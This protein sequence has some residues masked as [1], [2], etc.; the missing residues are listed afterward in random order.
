M[1]GFVMSNYESWVFDT[2]DNGLSAVLFICGAVSHLLRDRKL[3]FVTVCAIIN[4][5]LWPINF[6][7]ALRNYLRA[8]EEELEQDCIP[9]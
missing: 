3:S 7:L 5:I 1:G 8:R 6:A 9:F 4:S 2:V